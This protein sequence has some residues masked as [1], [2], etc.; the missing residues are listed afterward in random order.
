MDG[1]SLQDFESDAPN[2]TP[3]ISGVFESGGAALGII[4][5]TNNDRVA[6]NYFEVP[7][8]PGEGRF[9]STYSGENT[10][11]LPSFG[12][13]PLS[14]PLVGT[15]VENAEFFYNLFDDK[16]RVAVVAVHLGEEPLNRLT[17]HIINRCYKS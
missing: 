10:N 14:V 6:R 9:I 11:P 4:K 12:G 13:E 8:I 2:Y 5:R 3:R 17:T 16:I 1:H 15:A 7:F